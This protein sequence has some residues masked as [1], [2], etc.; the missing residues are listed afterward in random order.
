M[1]K[2]FKNNYSSSSF[3]VSCTCKD[4]GVTRTDVGVITTALTPTLARFWAFEIETHRTTTN[5]NSIIS[6][7]NKTKLII[8][9]LSIKIA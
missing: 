3:H 7:K 6:S 2:I 5:N 4:P 8:F 9:K 1:I